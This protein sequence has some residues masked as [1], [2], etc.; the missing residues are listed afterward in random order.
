MTVGV[1]GISELT[2]LRSSKPTWYAEYRHSA[3]SLTRALGSLDRIAQVLSA[4]G[5]GA[6]A[7]CRAVVDATADHLGAAWV[8]LAVAEDALP[9]AAPRLVARGPAGQPVR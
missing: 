5:R 6:D 4:T 3:D 9:L 7:L 8:V 1:P 2:G